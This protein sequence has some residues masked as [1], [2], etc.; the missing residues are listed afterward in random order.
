MIGFII[1]RFIHDSAALRKLGLT[2]ELGVP[3]VLTVFVYAV[4]IFA[5]SS[6]IHFFDSIF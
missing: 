6:V 2:L 3:F 5:D 1:R 4:C